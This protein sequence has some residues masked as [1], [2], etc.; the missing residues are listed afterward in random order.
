V[1]QLDAMA[2]QQQ[3]LQYHFN[4]LGQVIYNGQGQLLAT[5]QEITELEAELDNTEQQPAGDDAM[6][7][8]E[9]KAEMIEDL[10]A[11]IANERATL[12]QIQQHMNQMIQQRGA[13]ALQIQQLQQQMNAQYQ[14]AL[15]LYALATQGPLAP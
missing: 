15:Q 6:M 10:N 13:L 1:L 5:Q 14:H 4:Q 9:E 8:E 7:T 2:A 3:N 11:D 12:Q